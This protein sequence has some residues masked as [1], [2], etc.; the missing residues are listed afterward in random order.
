M[1]HAVKEDITRINDGSQRPPR[2]EVHQS[3]WAMMSLGPEGTELP[4]EEKFER[5]ADAGF[6]GILARVPE[7]H[8][9]EDWKRLLKQYELSFG[10]HCF[11]FQASDLSTH[12]QQANEFEMLYVNAQAADSF[13]VDEDA[14]QLLDALYAVAKTQGTPFF[15]ETHRGKI[16][17]DLIRT[18]AY[19]KNRPHLRF[20]LDLSHYV[21]AGEMTERQE[22]AEPL[23]QALLQRTSAIHGRISSG[24]QI[25]V[26]IR[27]SSAMVERFADW[28]TQA[29]RYWLAEAKPGDI[30]PFVCELGPAPY[31][32]TGLNGQELTDRWEQALLLKQLAEECWK[33]A[34]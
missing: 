3:M 1:Q 24:E 8:D 4:L 2:L 11:P 17:Q 12:L 10:T 20:T 29:M 33:R 15:V 26:D 13:V 9:R 21:L 23:I 16:T 25:Q 7:A 27:Q 30:L 19:T 5:I 14:A 34:K 18:V 31:A 6:T 22:K 28:W 32:I